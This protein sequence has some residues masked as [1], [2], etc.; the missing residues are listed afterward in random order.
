MESIPS[1]CQ[2]QEMPAYL[3]ESALDFLR[4]LN[5]PSV[6]PMCLSSPTIMPIGEEIDL[7]LHYSFFERCVTFCWFVL[8]PLIALAELWLRLFAG[9][10]APGVLCYLIYIYLSPSSSVCRNDSSQSI[11]VLIVCGVASSGILITDAMY[12]QEYG[13]SFGA[14]LFIAMIFLLGILENVSSDH[15]T[16]KE[17]TKLKLPQ[18]YRTLIAVITSLTVRALVNDF[19]GGTRSI[20]LPNVEAG[21]YFDSSSS[22]ISHVVKLWIEQSKVSLEYDDVGTKYLLTGDSRTGIPFLVNKVESVPDY[23]RRW[24]AIPE[25]NEAV[26]LDIAFPL[27]G[28]YNPNKPVYLV[29]HG[30]NGGSHEEYIMEFVSR[31]TKQ[32]S[33]VCV[34]VARGLMDTPIYGENVF[35]GARITDTSAAAKALRMVMKNDQAL[36]GAGY[37]MGAIVMANY[38]AQSGKNCQLDAAVII[39]GG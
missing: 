5:L 6:H 29:L 38:V 3:Q 37:S 30:L 22:K 19:R 36:V 23:V 17:N 33:T 1:W 12:V 14:S 32:G 35:H 10:I 21:L 7:S 28:I 26:A 20:D 16:F 15:K 13:R 11:F 8:P 18:K 4:Q 39:S 27:D 24:V 34:M 31:E 25:D 9:F 2:A